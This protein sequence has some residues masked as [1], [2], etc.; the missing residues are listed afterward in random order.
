MTDEIEERAM[1]KILESLRPTLAEL[2]KIKIGGKGEERPTKSGGK[3]RLP[4][5]HSY[6]TIT[7]TDRD[8]AGDLK[9]DD[10]LMKRLLEKHGVE[11]TEDK[12]GVKTTTR[13]LREIPIA[14]LSDSI[15]EVLQASFCFYD[16]RALVA[17][18]DGETCVWYRD[19]KGNAI[20]EGKAVPCNKE[21][22]KL[23]AD[24]KPRFKLHAKFLCTI[25]DG[26][27]RWGGVYA[28]RT[29][30]KISL[31]QL[32][33]TL[34][35][36]KALTGGILAG[37][38]LRLVVRG[39]EVAPEGKSS[40]VYVVHIELRGTDLNA[41]Q[42]QALQMAQVRLKNAKELA[43]VGQQYRALLS[44]PGENEDPEEQADVAEEFHPE[45]AA[46]AKAPAT[47]VAAE[48]QTPAGSKLKINEPIEDAVIEPSDPPAAPQFEAL[49]A[50]VPA[51]PAAA[52]PSPAAAE[53]RKRG[54]K[55]AGK[56]EPA[57]APPP[58]A[59]PKAPPPGAPGGEEPPTDMD[60]IPF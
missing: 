45:T 8:S 47:R 52:P 48:S 57:A 59:A 19:A 16:G 43:T 11:V 26:D 21:H 39:I 40:T 1:P 49:D 17:R 34:Q 51:G 4:E 41:V 50:P 27:A 3:F 29:T 42:Q 31:E 14:L 20:P 55:A 15:E 10:T 33:G 30:S 44:A 60:D 37:L 22:E 5:K 35:H 46:L 23:G 24:S 36:I 9:V 13:R 38:P 58:A 6:F 25:A 28:L 53:A 18:C 2:G 56:E 54:R 7:G 12:K 32:F